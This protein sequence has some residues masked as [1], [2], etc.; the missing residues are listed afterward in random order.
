MCLKE[1]AIKGNGYSQYNRDEDQKWNA[2]IHL[3]PLF[4]WFSDEILTQIKN[5]QQLY[6]QTL[7]FDVK[8]ICTYI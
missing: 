6:Y 1:T 5:L 7:S 2:I 8:Y 3:I 4:H